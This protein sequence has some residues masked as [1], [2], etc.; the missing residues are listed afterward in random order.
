M[1]NSHI[2]GPNDLNAPT[3][4]TDAPKT[5]ENDPEIEALKLAPTA[6]TAAYALKKAH[7]SVNFTSG[8]RSKEDQA[9]AMASNVVKNRKW[10]EE[11]YLNSLLRKRCQDWVDNHPDKRTQAEIQQG[12]ISVFNASDD[13]DLSKFSK[14]LSG[15]AFDVQPVENNA[16]KIKQT[17]RGLSELDKFLEKEGG[18]VRWHAQFK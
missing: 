13:D 9:H 6:R 16:E 14:H 8:R 1:A 10:I 3:R 7:P 11:T 15:M 4:S 5:A 17:I 18:L 2:P 12:L